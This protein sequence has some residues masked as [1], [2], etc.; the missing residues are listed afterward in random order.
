MS[1]VAVALA[2]VT[3][4]WCPSEGPVHHYAIWPSDEMA[5]DPIVVT[6]DATPKASFP[7]SCADGKR[8][9]VAFAF[10]ADG[11]PSDVSLD[12]EVVVC[13]GDQGF[14]T[15]GDGVV[16]GPDFGCFGRAYGCE[17]RASLPSADELDCP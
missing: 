5:G 1:C 4:A 9:Y 3:F 15:N 10:D 13:T 11:N 17:V 8:S 12:S 14:D 16:G 7:C 2:A 6:P